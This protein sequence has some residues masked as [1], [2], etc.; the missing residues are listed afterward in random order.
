MRYMLDLV[1]LVS[2][3]AARLPYTRRQAVDHTCRKRQRHGAEQNQQL[4][5]CNFLVHKKLI[6]HT[7]SL[8]NRAPGPAVWPSSHVAAPYHFL[9]P[10]EIKIHKIIMSNDNDKIVQR[11]LWLELQVQQLSG[12]VARRG[13]VCHNG[14][15]DMVQQDGANCWEVSIFNLCIRVDV[16]RDGIHPDMKRQI[17]QLQGQRAPPGCNLIPNTFWV[18]VGPHIDKS[19]ASPHQIFP[20][21]LQWSQITDRMIQYYTTIQYFFPPFNFAAQ[22]VVY[23]VEQFCLKYGAYAG[24]LSIW[25]GGGADTKAGTLHGFHNLQ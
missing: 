25:W 4:E 17:E 10:I 6:H 22:C 24:I 21:L 5:A 3:F 16:L 18:W 23:S 7:F 12:A 14:V 2:F 19:S 13:W 11:L 20:Y 9:K 8:H 1:V 15:N